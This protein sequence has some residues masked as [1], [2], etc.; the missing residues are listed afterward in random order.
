MLPRRKRA[1]RLALLAPAVVW[2][3]CVNSDVR[4]P[5][6][7]LDVS[8]PVAR[9]Q[10]ADIE[11]GPVLRIAGPPPA[12]TA[13]T[14]APTPPQADANL[15]A[16]RS[17][18]RLA[19]ERHATLDGYVARLRRREQV[20]AK[21]GP[22][23]EL[24]FKWRKQPWSVYFKWLGNVGQGREVL[25]VQGQHDNL[26][27]TLLAA[28]DMP[29]VPA[30]KQ[31]ALALDNIFVRAASRH[32]ITEAGIGNLIDRFGTALAGME[33]GDTRCGSMRYL[34]RVQRPE[35][36]A[37]MDAVEHVL[38]PGTETAL[39]KGGRRWVFFDPQTHLPVLMITHD[40][41]G[42]EVEYY[43]YDQVQFPVRLTDADFDPAV[44]WKK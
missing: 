5:H 13:G 37:P 29:L 4:Q 8:A 6:A 35:N 32:P 31:M 43:C 34:G 10:M 41:T 24:L 39:P 22:E 36:A 21:D 25:Y 15:D 18:Y 12:T 17:L 42:H 38:P 23:E 16:L 27:H 20:N 44:L 30:G 19:A 33:R 14:V 26:I 7:V 9:G 2:C 40:E 1:R 3:G 11:S 28:G